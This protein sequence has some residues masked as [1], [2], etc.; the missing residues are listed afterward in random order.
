MHTIEKGDLT[1]A[2]L[3]ARL[4]RSR[5]V[6]L[7]PVTELSRYDLVIDRG[8]G[9]ERVQ[10]KTGKISAG[11]VRFNTCSF[12][13]HHTTE[14]KYMHDYVG[15]AE[16]FGVYCPCNDKCYLVPVGDVKKRQG[17]LRVD[18]AL[19]NQIKGIRLAGAYEI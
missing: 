19:N 15:Q 18:A 12:S 3:I 5:F 10:C 1:V 2:M 9:F 11:S 8:S 7:R 4:M 16:L 17:T 14:K 6:V 13:G